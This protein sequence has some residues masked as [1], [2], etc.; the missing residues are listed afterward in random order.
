MFWRAKGKG[1]LKSF[2]IKSSE[3]KVYYKRDL[4][5][6]FLF[7]SLIFLFMSFI[8]Y[9]PTDNSWLYFSSKAI[10]VSNWC[11]IIGANASAGFFFLFGGASYIFLFSI[12]FSIF[13]LFDLLPF[14]FSN[15]KFFLFPVLLLTVAATLN[16][17]KYDFHDLLPG[18]IVGRFFAARLI[19]FFGEKG[20]FIFLYS[21]I[22][23]SVMILTR[24]SIASFIMSS[25]RIFF[26]VFT[27]IM[28]AILGALDFIVSKIICLFKFIFFSILSLFRKEKTA[29]SFEDSFMNHFDIS[30]KQIIG[31]KQTEI[32]EDVELDQ[33]FRIRVIGNGIDV[34]FFGYDLFLMRNSVLAKNI[35]HEIRFFKDSDNVEK[36]QRRPEIS[37][38]D[39]KLDKPA[40]EYSL[41]DFSR[42]QEM[43][44]EKIEREE[45]EEKCR[46]RG[47]KLEEKLLHFGVKGKVVA[48]RP[49]PVIT[50]FEYKPEID[51]KISRIIALEDDLAMALTALSIRIIAPIPGKSVVGFEISNEV[52]QDVFLSEVLE[53]EKVKNFSGR[54]PLVLGVDIIGKPVV[55]DLVAMPH[56]LVAGSTGSGKSVGLNSILVSLLCSFSPDDLKIILI[57]PKRLEFAP[58]ADVPHLLFPIVTNP[59]KSIPVLK[60]VVQEMEDRYNQMMEI[61]VRNIV[62]YHKWYKKNKNKIQRDE[63]GL[64]VMPFIVLIIDELADLMMVA[65][66]DIEIYITRLSQ[67]ARA[68]GIH[69]IAATQRPSVDVLTGVIKA[70]FP[71]RISFRVS[72]KIDSRTIL[73]GSGAEKLLGKGDMLFVSPGTSSPQRIHSPYVSS[74]EISRLADYLKRQ[75]EVNYLDLKEVLRVENAG[76][77]SQVEDDIY[78]EVKEFISS[79][80]EISISF[81]QRKYR[82]GFNRSARLIEKLELDGLVAPSGSGKMRKVIR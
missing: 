76:D 27:A 63:S 71:A 32:E 14:K 45:F 36:N 37:N 57:D 48:I 29:V 26:I 47:E 43:R 13:F 82:I 81:L 79:V 21:V 12:L 53:E 58:Y 65:G 66:K 33:E 15:Y 73:D 75:Q 34:R 2:N 67:M 40:I 64:S 16:I 9:K 3:K 44:S 55:R 17:H 78:D 80:D 62:D 59:L 56:A 6:I 42:F 39:K 54:I 51:S 30:G 49:G 72:S 38:I 41:P 23:C 24:I 10:A 11:G 74:I 18:G 31:A 8:S 7:S 4:V 25:S 70:N 50:L 61:G 77:Q 60:W 35:L 28:Q 69:M 20:S 46:K 19:P 5:G 1:S 22:I 68:A 52:R